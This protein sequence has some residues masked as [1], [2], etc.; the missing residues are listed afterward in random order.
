MRVAVPRLPAAV[1]LVVEGRSSRSPARRKREASLLDP[2]Q[3]KNREEEEREMGERLLREEIIMW[4]SDP[5]RWWLVDRE[6]PC[7]QSTV[8]TILG[9]ITYHHTISYLILH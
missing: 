9:L 4:A 8:E 6:F 3:N 2:N 7:F 1:P 5:P